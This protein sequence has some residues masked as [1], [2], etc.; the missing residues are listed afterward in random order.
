MLEAAA[1][2]EHRQVYVGVGVGTA[3]AGAVEHHRAV[4]QRPAPFVGRFQRLE[5]ASQRREL[6][7]LDAPQ[8]PE[9]L[10]L[11]AVVRE[12]VDGVGVDEE[13]HGSRR[14]GVERQLDHVEEQPHPLGKR[15]LVGIVHRRRG[16]H[17]RLRLVLPAFRRHQPLLEIPHGGAILVHPLPV[18]SREPLVEP[19]R[20]PAHEV[21][22]ALPLLHA[23]DRG[24]Y[25][26]G[27]ARREQLLEQFMGAVLGRNLRPRPREA[28]R[29]ALETAG[30]HQRRMPRLVTDPLGDILIERDAVAKSAPFGVRG[31]GDEA[32]LGRMSAVHARVA[33]AGKDREG[34]ADGGE[35]LKVG[36]QLIVTAGLLRKEELRQDPHVGLDGDHPL[37]G[38]RGRG[39]P[40]GRPHGVE[41]RQGQRDARPTQE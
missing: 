28:L 4:E 37:R 1:G 35:F 20:L 40:E 25:L 7:V 26:L 15:L 22:Q 9:F 41:H 39:R 38:G 3:H 36:R 31:A 12:A 34:I 18:G 27:F 30:D 32:F 23:F 29:T 10:R 2:Q 17:H 5:E 16:F 8:F 6:R 14:V 19:P 33:R 11:V 13:R 21:E 24:G